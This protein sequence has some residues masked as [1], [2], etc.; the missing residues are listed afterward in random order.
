MIYKTLT[1]VLF[2]TV[3]GLLSFFYYKKDVVMD[4][5]QEIIQNINE[6]MRRKYS[7]QED[8]VN[9]IK[10]QEEEDQKLGQYIINMMY[11]TSAGKKLSDAKKQTLARDIVRTANE[12]FETTEHKRAF[13]VV[14]AIESEFQ[15]FAQ[16]PTG[17]KGYSQ[18]AKN[19]FKEAMNICGLGD[20]K[21]DDVWDQDLNLLAGACYFKMALERNNNDTYAAIVAYNQGPNSVSAK[22]YS[23]S[24]SLD[25]IEA[26]KYIAKFT[27]LKRKV[28][29][30][31][32]EE[33]V[34]NNDKEEPTKDIKNK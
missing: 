30:V 7:E 25:N 19:S 6:K 12:I 20:V 31:K 14:I 1:Y 15:K 26:L 33:L 32:P 29:D 13:V 24:G 8:F 10:Q 28:N 16:S 11:H 22:T 18:V 3:A 4:N 5:R 27:F 2:A 23:K 9:K 21:D 34:S 17:P